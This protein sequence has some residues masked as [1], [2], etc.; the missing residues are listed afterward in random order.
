MNE[1]SKTEIRKKLG[2]ITQLQELLFGDKID[3]YNFKL[4]QYNQRLDTL[5][6][7]LQKSQR[8]IEASI[9]Q[10]EQKLFEQINS[11]VNALEKSSQD[12]ILKIQAEQHK[13]QQRLDKIAQYSNEH[14]DFLHQSLDTKTNS[15]KTE[16]IQTKYT[17]NQDLNSVKQ[18][19]LAKLEDNL[20][21]LTAKKISRADL[22]EV[23]FELSLK[24]KRTDADL[25]TD[26]NFSNLEDSAVSTEDSS[27][28]NLMLPETKS[29][30]S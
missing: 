28:T 27:Q 15:L 24:L 13:L 10:S 4:D 20:A 11:V 18:E 12:Q 1:I 8:T 3:E 22:A 25:N 29:F 5:E 6:A 9:A 19:I 21:E 16:I 26:L 30:D 2:N 23:L 14:L 17:L 7:N